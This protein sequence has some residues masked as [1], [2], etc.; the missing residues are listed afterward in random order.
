MSMTGNLMGDFKPSAELKAQLP[1]AILVGIQ[2]HRLVDRT[3][4]QFAPV[5]ELRLVFSSDRRRFAGIISDIAFD[6]FLIKHWNTFTTIDF[7]EFIDT[8]YDGLAECRHWMPPRMQV[9]VD[10]FRQ[11]DWLRAYA[12]LEGI[13]QTI[14]QVSKRLR[15]TNNMAGGITEVEA[16]YSLLESVFLA[17]FR[18]LINVVEQA[19]IESPSL[20]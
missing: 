8:A 1:A 4:D 19:E 14:N 9:V 15:F 13:D 5:K 6:Y 10:N 11:Y 20:Q 7:D 12:S 3:T 2:N 18:H 17:L 16:N